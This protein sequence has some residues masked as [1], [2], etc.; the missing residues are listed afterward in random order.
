MSIREALTAISSL[1]PAYGLQL[2]S[3]I[4]NRLPHRASTNVGQIYSTLSRLVRDG[5]L[6]CEETTD[7]GLPLYR[8][9]E[10]HMPQVKTWLSGATLTVN[11]PLA[12]ALDVLLLC[13]SIPAGP[14]EQLV[15]SIAALTVSSPDGDDIQAKIHKRY[16]DLLVAI[17][18]DIT[19]ARA[20]GTILALDLREERPHRGRRPAP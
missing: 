1:G 20:Q 9:N 18:D 3:E 14:W 12:D 8:L 11:T 4:V 17:A 7:D 16:V 10:A 2:H 15:A 6:L 19:D 5:D 13:A